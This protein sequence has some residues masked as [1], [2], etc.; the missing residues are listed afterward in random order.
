MRS[1]ELLS[2][3]ANVFCNQ[4]F[5]V[6]CDEIFSNSKLCQASDTRCLQLCLPSVIQVYK[7]D[8]FLAVVIH[9]VFLCCD[10][11]IWHPLF[12]AAAL[13]LFQDSVCFYFVLFPL[14]FL[15]SSGKINRYGDSVAK[16][17]REQ[18]SAVI[19]FS[20]FVGALVLLFSCLHVRKSPGKQ[21]SLRL[22]SCTQ[23]LSQC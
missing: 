13:L 8:I 16:G 2:L 18:A 11:P 6:T 23:V 21:Q 4:T 3:L 9:T 7:R 20:D 14:R 15:T 19:S 10:F 22:I 12:I 5:Q 17:E 1:R